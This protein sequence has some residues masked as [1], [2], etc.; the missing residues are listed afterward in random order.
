MNKKWMLHR[1]VGGMRA[2]VGGGAHVE[3][4]YS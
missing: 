3:Y 1:K 4:I 2:G